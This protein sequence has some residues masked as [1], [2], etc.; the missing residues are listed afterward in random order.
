MIACHASSI[1][2]IIGKTPLLMDQLSEEQLISRILLLDNQNIVNQVIL[3][4]I[5]NAKRFSWDIM[6]GN[7]VALYRDAIRQYNTQK[8]KG[9][10]GDSP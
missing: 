8:C 3:D 7:Y 10:I 9:I 5:E 6:V 4:G 1:P 2:E